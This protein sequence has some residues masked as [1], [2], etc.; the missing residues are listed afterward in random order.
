MR[1]DPAMSDESAPRERPHE[2]LLSMKPV[3]KRPNGEAPSPVPLRGH[4]V[5]VEP[6]DLAAHARDLFHAGHDGEAARTVWAF[7]PYGPFE[8]ERGFAEW[9]RACAMFNDPLFFAIRDTASGKASGMASYL[10][11]RPSDGVIEMGHIWFAPA[12]RHSKAAT[13]ALFLLMRQVFDQLGYRRLEWKCNAL[14]GPSRRAALRLGFRFE[15]IFYR[16]MIVKGCN[17]DTAW[18]SI[19]DEEWPRLR[20]GIERWLADDNFNEQGRQRRPMRD[21]LG[22]P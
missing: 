19:I 12:L 18:Y 7:L 3:A 10:N 20:V 2:R 1:H 14:N 16:H 4:A 8:N 9:L 17:R 13:E 22:L 6:L 21:L 5:C 11:V 15:G